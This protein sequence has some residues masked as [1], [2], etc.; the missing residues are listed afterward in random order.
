MKN[1]FN[2]KNINLNQKLKDKEIFQ[3][4]RQILD[5]IL[6]RIKIIEEVSLKFEIRFRILL[7]MLR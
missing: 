4:I 2:N 1:Q 3:L 7:M 6:K 5:F